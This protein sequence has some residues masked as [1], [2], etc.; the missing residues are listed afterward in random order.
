MYKILSI[1]STISPPSAGNCKI[2]KVERKPLISLQE[3]KSIFKKPHK[4]NLDKIKKVLQMY[5]SDSD[6]DFEDVIEHDYSL[7]VVNDCVLYYLTGYLSFQILNKMKYE[8]CKNAI[9]KHEWHAPQEILADFHSKLTHPNTNFY[10]FIKYLDKVFIRH[11][12]FPNVFDLILNDI[13]NDK[14]LSFPC[15]EHK[16]DV[17]PFIIHYFVQIRMRQFCKNSNIN[18]IKE[19]QSRKKYAKH[20]KT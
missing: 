1:Y 14:M 19:N 13:T 3:L 8:V 16:N 2:L 15:S 9:V 5:I 17:I 6:W 12:N 7:P 20:C 18:Q 10:N 11:C 4:S